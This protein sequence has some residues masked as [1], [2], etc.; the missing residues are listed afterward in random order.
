MRFGLV[1]I[2]A[3]EEI[4]ESLIGNTAPKFVVVHEG[5]VYIYM[6]KVMKDGGYDK[7]YSFI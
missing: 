2:I 1:D 6:S 4:K 3:E 7:F 5:K